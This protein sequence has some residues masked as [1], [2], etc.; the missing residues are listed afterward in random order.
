MG[1]GYATPLD[2]MKGPREKIVYLPCIYS[3]TDIKKPD[4]LATV[5]VDPTSKDFC[6][7]KIMTNKIKILEVWILNNF[8]FIAI[9]QSIKPIIYVVN[10]S[11]K[12]I[13]RLPALHLED[14]L[15]HS[16]WNACSRSAVKVQHTHFH[17]PHNFTLFICS[18]HGDKSVTR[19]SLIMPSLVS[20]R[21]YVIDV[22]TDPC[23]P[24]I[25][26]VKQNIH[27]RIYFVAVFLCDFAFFHIVQVIEPKEVFEKTGLAYLHTSHCLANGDIM[28]SAMG[29]P[30]GEAKGL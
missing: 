15:H 24:R 27:I 21:I 9:S 11:F 4:Y 5:D 12:V 1:P 22:A 3:N 8:T 13:H 18:C 28:I 6:K 30:K 14:E 26:K 7:V 16:G 10:T 19:D 20:S 23:A 25:R 2:A 29:N 17:I